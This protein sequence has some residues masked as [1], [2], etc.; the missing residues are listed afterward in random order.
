MNSTEYLEHAEKLFGET[1]EKQVELEAL[2]TKFKQEVSPLLEEINKTSN[3]FQKSLRESLTFMGGNK[4]LS[5]DVGHMM[6]LGEGFSV[7]DKLEI[8]EMST[9]TL[10]ARRQGKDL[11]YQLGASSENINNWFFDGSDALFKLAVDTIPLGRKASVAITHTKMMKESVRVIN[12][13]GHE[14]KVRASAEGRTY[15]V[16]VVDQ[17]LQKSL[18][19]NFTHRCKK[20]DTKLKNFDLF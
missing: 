1:R 2:F 10:K 19:Q 12:T 20:V 15:H 8:Y 11:L 16:R 7:E 5:M 14:F 9:A 4:K 3:S 13:Q 18:Y 17:K 6:E